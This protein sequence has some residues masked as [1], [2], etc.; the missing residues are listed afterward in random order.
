M[1]VD[2]CDLQVKMALLTL[3]VVLLLMVFL[4]TVDSLFSYL[5]A[6][7]LRQVPS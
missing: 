1:F 7:S 4:A 6:S 3:V 2:A 5:L